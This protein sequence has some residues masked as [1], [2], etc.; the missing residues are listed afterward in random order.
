MALMAV[1][2]QEAA[3]Q[4]AAQKASLMEAPAVQA[5]SKV[6]TLSIGAPLPSPSNRVL[7]AKLAN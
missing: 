3:L 6:V 2:V 5:P 1:V 4:G 7:L